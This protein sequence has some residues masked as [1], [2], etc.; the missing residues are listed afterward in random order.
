[1]IEIFL[2]L[3]LAGIMIAMSIGTLV[4]ILCV[5]IWIAER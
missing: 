2:G 4:A 1:M 3:L 5:V